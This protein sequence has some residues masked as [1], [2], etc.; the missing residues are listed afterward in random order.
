MAAK[1]KPVLA[2]R[3]EGLIVGTDSTAFL[4]PVLAI[5]RDS[6]L[7]YAMPDVPHPGAT[8]SPAPMPLSASEA[9]C[10]T[11]LVRAHMPELDSVR[12]VAIM[13]VM[14][15]H[16]FCWGMNFSRLPTL[17][18][19]LLEAMHVGKLGVNLFFVLSGFLITG[20]LLKARG[21]PTYYSRF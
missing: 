4:A 9:G 15:Y 7:T 8:A 5:P 11:P 2:A 18:E 13:M 17:E 10:E 14:F 21:R 12:G 1:R 3:V 20:L 16:A 19:R 6:R